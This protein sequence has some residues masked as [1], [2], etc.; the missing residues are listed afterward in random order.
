LGSPSA[1]TP[2]HR[3][4]LF[5][6]GIWYT[7]WT[8]LCSSVPNGQDCA[9]GERPR[10]ALKVRFAEFKKERNMEGDRSD[11]FRIEDSAESCGQ[12]KKCKGREQMG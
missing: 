3:N 8:P 12:L 1:S 11:C 6:A 4:G 9:H 2:Q 10:E 5:T 7:L